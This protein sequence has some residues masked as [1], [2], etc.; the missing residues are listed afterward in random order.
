MAV[1]IGGSTP[2]PYVPALLAGRS[3]AATMVPCEGVGRWRP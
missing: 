2:F 3:G 1:H